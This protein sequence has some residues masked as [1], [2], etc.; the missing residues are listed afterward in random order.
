MNNKIGILGGTFD[1]IHN[2]H[3]ALSEA[4]L[5]KCSLDRV[6]LMPTFDP[7]YK[8]DRHVSSFE[9]RLEMTRLACLGNEKLLASDFERE[10]KTDGYTFNTLKIL[11]EQNPYDEFYFIIGGDSLF[12]IEKW[13][14]IKE[15]FSMCTLLVS[16]RENEKAGASGTLKPNE[17]SDSRVEEKE[18]KVYNL[19]IELD[20]KINFLKK[21]YNAKIINLYAECVNV[22]SSSLRQMA[23]EGKS[24]EKF[25][26]LAVSEYI[27]KKKLYI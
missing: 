10:N 13:F 12:S 23:K 8:K 18:N 6:L 15:I 21:D 5:N 7:Y 2:G 16:K 25:V 3:I 9:D 24:L 26:P 17:N 1:P 19:D 14:K 27:I 22:S 11:K 4:A 20:E